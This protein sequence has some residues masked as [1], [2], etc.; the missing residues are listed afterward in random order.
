MSVERDLFL[1]L[2]LFLTTFCGLSLNSILGRC[3]VAPFAIHLRPAF[4]AQTH[5]ETLFLRRFLFV[6]GPG[7]VQIFRYMVR[8]IGS[9]ISY[10]CVNLQR[11]HFWRS[12]PESTLPA[13]LYL[14]F[15]RYP[16]QDF[17]SDPSC[18]FFWIGLL[19]ASYTFI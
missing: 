19:T 15:F 17:T 9:K 8:E 14:G 13:L 12:R 10:S 5:H 4:P 18:I 7:R 6:P 1:S 3:S 16:T 11:W 2:V